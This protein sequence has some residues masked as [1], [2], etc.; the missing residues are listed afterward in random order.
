MK[1]SKFNSVEIIRQASQT[2]LLAVVLFFVIRYISTN[3][4][5]LKERSWRIEW[6]FLLIAFFCIWGGFLLTVL[7]LRMVFSVF[8][9][10]V[11]YSQAWK[12]WYLPMLSKYVPGKVWT[13]LGRAYVASL[14]KVN[15]K[16]AITV[17]VISQI[18]V[19]PGLAIAF[20]ITIPFWKIGPSQYQV[21]FALVVLLA[22]VVLLYPKLFRFLANL[23]MRKIG[24]QRLDIHVKYSQ[25]LGLIFFGSAIWISYG[26]AFAVFAR[27]ITFVNWG[28]FPML[29]G[30]FCLAIL[31]VLVSV[32]AP[33]GIGVRE[34]ALL[35]VLSRYFTSDVTI[36]ISIGSRF[37]FIA[38]EIIF[39]GVSC[40][41]HKYRPSQ[42]NS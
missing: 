41:L 32:F 11:R 17:A 25:I 24:R 14:E 13:I 38:A 20:L 18:I 21:V 8:G 6:G 34:G 4:T 35:V 15:P 9:V 29:T 36:A 39:F 37:W 42:G 33:A 26:L 12:I 1:T 16:A 5:L 22:I 7:Y 2:I 27:S 31:L 30:S 19:F 10:S 28:D 3:F 40:V 23:V